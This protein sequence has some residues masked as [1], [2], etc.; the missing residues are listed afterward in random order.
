MLNKHL[1]IAFSS[2][3]INSA[4]SRMRVS[5]VTGYSLMFTCAPACVQHFPGL[6]YWGLSTRCIVWPFT[7]QKL[8]CS[9]VY[10]RVRWGSSVGL[11]H[12]PLSYWNEANSNVK[13]M[14]LVM[15]LNHSRSVMYYSTV[16]VFFVRF[17][18]KSLWQTAAHQQFA[19]CPSNIYK[20]PLASPTNELNL[21]PCI[22]G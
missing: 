2:W 12:T 22:F 14:T 21:F 16:W 13:H 15:L 1:L 7:G 8:W 19:M 5:M 6:Q 10:F 20:T 11:Q 17:A 18:V 9:L 3:S 4:S